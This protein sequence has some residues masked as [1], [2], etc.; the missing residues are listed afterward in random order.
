MKFSPHHL[1]ELNL[2]LQFDVSSAATGIKVHTDAAETIKNAVQRLYDK[3]LC[4]LPD[5]GYL[6]H[7]GIVMAEQADRILQV[8]S[9]P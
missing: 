2:L 5:G 3:G 4:T 1:D 8:L 6:T 9:H 7:E